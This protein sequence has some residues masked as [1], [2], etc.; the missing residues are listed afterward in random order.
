MPS[1][2]G[3]KRNTKASTSDWSEE[4]AACF[5]DLIQCDMTS[6]TLPGIDGTITNWNRNL[7]PISR[8]KRSRG[9]L[10]VS[11]DYLIEVTAHIRCF[12]KAANV[13]ALHHTRPALPRP[14]L[15]APSTLSASS[16][17]SIS[18]RVANY[19]G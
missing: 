18:P 16:A 1:P 9:W 17:C 15:P 12:S 8:F 4:I 6:K 14:L 3:L 13:C 7:T 19:H 5:F 10:D 11:E 2:M